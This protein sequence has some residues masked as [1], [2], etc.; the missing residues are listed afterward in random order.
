MPRKIILIVFSI[1]IFN[2]LS[3]SQNEY[4][5]LTQH[6]E[7]SLINSEP[8]SYL[9]EAFG[10]SALRISDPAIGI[11]QVYNYG[12]FDFNQ[13]NF[14]L[15][16]VR[17]YMK[18]YLSVSDI[19]RSILSYQY[20]G[21]KAREQVLALSQTQKQHIFESL[22]TNRKEENKYYFYDYFYD[23][24]ATKWRDLLRDAIGDR[25]KFNNPYPDSILS[26]RQL[27]HKYTGKHPWGE[28]GIDLAL[29]SPI[30]KPASFED[31]MYLPDYLRLAVKNATQ[32]DSLGRDQPLQKYEVDFAEPFQGVK[33][34]SDFFTPTEFFWIIFSFITLISLFEFKRQK[35]F[36]LLSAILILGVGLIGSTLMFLWF[37]TNHYTAAYNYN[38]LWA[39]P[40]NVIFA[41]FIFSNKQKIIEGYAVSQ[42]ALLLITLIFWPLW[43]QDLHEAFI[44]VVLILLIRFS[45]IAI[46]N[47]KQSLKIN[48]LQLNFT[49]KH[50]K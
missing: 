17:G 9:F 46:E 24:C 22:E 49:K 34:E 23:N 44:P 26:I 7:V 3:F 35:S 18:Y 47:R 43:P 4:P 21:I 40:T 1:L 27:M 48:N 12:T 14:Y 11:D 39:V 29:G 36:R 32:L 41:F 25:L 13:E 8:G 30:D 10:H 33:I 2:K 6:A 38:L 42:I 19:R 50:K 45:I 37:L 5:Q 20:R 15:N 28:F 31:Y 16:F